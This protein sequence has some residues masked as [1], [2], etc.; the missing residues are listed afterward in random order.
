MSNNN[1]EHQKVVPIEGVEA[2]LRG[3]LHFIWSV[4]GYSFTKMRLESGMHVENNYS[5]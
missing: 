4:S 5:F 1:P 3:K 2:F